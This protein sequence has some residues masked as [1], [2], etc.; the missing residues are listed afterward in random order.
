MANNE[1]ET[2]ILNLLKNINESDRDVMSDSINMN[3]IH[4]IQKE[5]IKSVMFIYHALFEPSIDKT[6]SYC[7]NNEIDCFFMFNKYSKYIH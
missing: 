3:L 7:L 2:S 6:I 5:N 1:L 4:L